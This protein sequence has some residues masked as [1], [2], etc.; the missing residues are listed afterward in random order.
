MDRIQLTIC[1]A[2]FYC[3]LGVSCSTSSVVDVTDV[4][5][6]PHLLSEGRHS[7]A[8]A[9]YLLGVGQGSVDSMVVTRF[10]PY[11]EVMALYSESVPSRMVNSSYGRYASCAEL[12][13]YGE[14]VVEWRP[15]AAE[16]NPFRLTPEQ[17]QAT[18]QSL[19]DR[20]YWLG[21]SDG[22]SSVELQMAIAYYRYLHGADVQC[23]LYPYDLMLK[24]T[25]CMLF[26]EDVRCQQKYE[27]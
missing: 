3:L 18:Q 11:F 25:Y 27:F 6:I 2:L 1:T 16:G 14:P 13:H 8:L 5:P 20:G 21:A 15:I 19:A 10:G 26:E 9:Q 12:T 22:Q 4:K 17:V 24:S 7:E 23:V